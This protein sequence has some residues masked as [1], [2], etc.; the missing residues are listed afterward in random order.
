[1]DTFI[2]KAKNM[3]LKPESQNFLDPGLPKP[4]SQLNLRFENTNLG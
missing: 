3:F 4:W 1:M 2:V